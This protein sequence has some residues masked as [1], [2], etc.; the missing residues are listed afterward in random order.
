LEHSRRLQ[1]LMRAQAEARGGMLPFDRFME[2][3]LYAPGLGYYAAGARKL[4][5]GGDFV[6][7]PEICPL[8]GRCLARQCVEVLDALG[9]GDVLEL[10]AGTGALAADL[11]SALAAEDRLPGRYLILEPS[12]DLRARQR[13][14]LAARLPRLAD[15]VA[16]LDRLPIGFRGLLIANEVADAIPVHRFLVGEG[17]AVVEGFVR[18]AGG[19]WEAVAAPPV[20]PGLVE[21]VAALQADGLATEPG[22]ASE[23]NLR[24]GPWAAA[25]AAALGRGLALVIDYGYPRA[26]Y[27][28]PQRR[29]GTLMCHH[30]HQAHADPLVHVGLQ[31]ITA[32]VDFSALAVAAGAAGLTLSGFTTQTH[33]LLGCG[34]E[35]LIAEALARGPVPELLLGA[36]QLVMPAGMGERFR[37]LGLAKGVEG[38]W[39]GFS[40]RDLR[41]RL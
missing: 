22:Y 18:P 1:D 24:L 9:D 35:E 19:G 14:L 33:F 6:T 10:G 36:K 40:L 28:H 27:Y 17:G 31:D 25:L 20:S 7:A 30:R 8:F 39:R 13:G 4:G 37:V 29:A 38:P 16:W 11:L 41:G 23:V 5:P 3:A 12:S 21:A 26:E 34:L 32:H 2:L 15:R